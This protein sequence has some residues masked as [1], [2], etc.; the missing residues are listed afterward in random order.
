[1]MYW[2]SVMVLVKQALPLAHPVHGCHQRL[3]WAY[4]CSVPIER[5]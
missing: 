5:C 1:M 4:Q 2:S 3:T